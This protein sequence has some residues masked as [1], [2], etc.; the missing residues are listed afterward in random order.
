MK[1]NRRKPTL[2]KTPTAEARATATL[3][4][5]LSA[6]LSSG[7][8][9]S[10]RTRAMLAGSL[11]SPLSEVSCTFRCP[12]T[13]IERADA[14]AAL[15]PSG[16]ETLN[17]SSVLRAALAAGLTVLEQ[18]SKAQPADLAGVL[19]ELDAMRARVAALTTEGVE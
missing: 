14:I 5:K 16:G 18:R 1:T 7:S 3:I 15:P 10:A 11:E 13:L 2:S 19:A 8:V 12:A 4:A 6:R 9:D 17:R